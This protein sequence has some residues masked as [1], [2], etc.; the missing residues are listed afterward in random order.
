MLK[1][2]LHKHEVD[3]LKQ[4]AVE[5]S[6]VLKNDK[7]LCDLTEAVSRISE[8]KRLCFLHFFSHQ[9]VSS[10]LETIKSQQSV[11]TVN[12]LQSAKYSDVECWWNA[13]RFFCVLNIY[14]YIFFVVSHLEVK[15]DLM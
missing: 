14:V 13:F 9:S 2:Y 3:I 8:R 5:K 1:L 7:L 11:A 10:V 4:K 6:K 15:I 12:I